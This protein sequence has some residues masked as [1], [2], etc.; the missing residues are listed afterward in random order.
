M[1][2][3]SQLSKLKLQRKIIR[4]AITRTIN[5]LKRGWTQGVFARTANGEQCRYNYPKAV[6]WC[7]VGAMQAS[8]IH[9]ET[10]RMIRHAAD[11]VVKDRNSI[12][13]DLMTYNDRAETKRRDVI[14]VLKQVYNLVGDNTYLRHLI[15]VA[16]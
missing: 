14:S 3:V 9:Y 12:A 11:C 15:K 13:I 4:A 8:I 5:R 10:Y 16:R 7:A 2:S 1:A 6:K